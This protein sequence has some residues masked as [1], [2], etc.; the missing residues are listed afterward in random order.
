[1]YQIERDGTSTHCVEHRAQ[2]AVGEQVAGW[3]RVLAE[4]V[5]VDALG[6]GAGEGDAL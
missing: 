4:L 2:L 3:K 5:L 1:M 6:R